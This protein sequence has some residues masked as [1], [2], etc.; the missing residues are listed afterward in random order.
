MHI[1]HVSVVVFDY[2]ERVGTVISEY[3][4]N[5]IVSLRLPM[6]T[7]LQ[8]KLENTHSPVVIRNVD[9]ALEL[10][11]AQAMLQQIGVKSI[12]VLPMIVQDDLIGAVHLDAFYDYRDFTVE[13]VEAATAVTSQLAVSAHNAQLYQELRRRAHQLE[14]I[15]ELSRRVTSTFDRGEIYQIAREETQKIIDADV[16]AVGLRSPDGAL[17]TTYI[18]MEDGPI[19]ADFPLDRAALRFVFNTVEP[20]VL[21]DISGSDDPDYRLFTHSGMRAAA[22]VPL[23]AGGRAIGAY[24]VLHREP[25]H[26]HAIDLAVLEQIGNQL[27][28]ALEN[29]RLYTQTLQRAETE[30]LMNRLSGSIQGRGDLQDMVLG[31]VQEIAD[32]LGARRARVRLE[33]PKKI[34]GEIPRA[35][36]GRIL[37]RLGDRDR[38]NRPELRS[39]RPD[40]EK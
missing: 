22:I 32:A 17:L 12:A 21:D 7:P 36:A 34:T 14:R 40:S 5:G 11:S 29:A 31:T 39:T 16:V 20:L 15:T 24:C 3:P 28:I 10:S 4:D 23:I 30:R 25:S 13:E 1:D 19:V 35:A 26:Y 9:T 27:A 37:E 6:S 38:P 33:M 2:K 8:E 18:L